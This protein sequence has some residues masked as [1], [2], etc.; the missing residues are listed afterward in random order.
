[1]TLLRAEISQIWSG[2]ASVTIFSSALKGT[3]LFLEAGATTKYMAA[4]VT[5]LLQVK[6]LDRSY[7]AA[8]EMIPWQV[9]D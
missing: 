9:S 8:L 7:T 3:T 1:M 2:V 6:V 5:T 4:T